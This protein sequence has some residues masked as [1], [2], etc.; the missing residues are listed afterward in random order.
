[1]PD[2]SGPPPTVPE[3]GSGIAVVTGAAGGIGRAVVAALR[4]AGH[5]LVGVDRVQ[6]PGDHDL[7]GDVSDP[8]VAEELVAAVERD[9]G[10]IDVLVNCAGVLSNAPVLETTAADWAAV[11]AANATSVFGMSGAVARRMVPRRRGSIVTVA[12]N[13]GRIPR[14]GMAAYGA[15]KAAAALFTQSLGLELA[16]HGIRCN[17]VSPGTTRTPMVGAMLADDGEA[18]VVAGDPARFKTGIPL[19]RLAEPEDVAAAVAF[20]VSPAARHVTMH[21]L[22][23]DGGATAGR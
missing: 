4:A 8:A 11:L 15:S 19:R 14:H 1:M 9:R 3:P 2:P 16:E 22:V 6:P 10:P 23:V 21:D 12:S 7:V 17:V 13:A 20:L 18:G 5:E